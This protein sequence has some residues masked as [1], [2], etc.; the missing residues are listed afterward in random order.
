MGTLIGRIYVFDYN[1]QTVETK[2]LEPQRDNPVKHLS[3]DSEGEQYV[4]FATRKGQ[5]GKNNIY[6]AF[7]SKEID[8]KLLNVNSAD[9]G[10]KNNAIVIGT[11]DGHIHSHC[12]D[13][14]NDNM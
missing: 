6:D 10:F 2:M 9:Y 7:D 8:T 5:I 1:K 11:E 12:F 13:N 14:N 4:I 3:F